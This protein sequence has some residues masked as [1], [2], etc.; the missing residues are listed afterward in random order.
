MKR[1]VLSLICLSLPISGFAFSPVLEWSWTSSAVEPSA[2][3]VM[4]TPSVVD[5]NK[6]FSNSKISTVSK[7]EEE[8]FYS[9]LLRREFEKKNKNPPY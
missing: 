5:L 2:L 1:I 7:E 9:R 8:K 3:N 6:E 4:G